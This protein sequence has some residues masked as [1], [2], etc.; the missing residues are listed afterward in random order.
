MPK[1]STKLFK[2]L[3]RAYEAGENLLAIKDRTGIN[4]SD[5]SVGLRLVGCRMRKQG[6]VAKIA[7]GAT[8]E[9]DR[10]QAHR[11]PSTET[12]EPSNQDEH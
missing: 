2:E 3:R 12:P 4:I 6:R 9:H 7:G 1:F 11:E 8:S 10:T 5:L